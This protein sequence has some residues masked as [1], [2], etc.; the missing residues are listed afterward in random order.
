MKSCEKCL[1]LYD[2]FVVLTVL[3]VH[4]DKYIKTKIR[5]YAKKLVFMS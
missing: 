1:K 2:K 4:D 3:P 5:T